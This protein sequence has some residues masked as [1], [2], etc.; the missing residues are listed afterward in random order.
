VSETGAVIDVIGADNGSREFLQEVIILVGALGRGEKGK[1]VGPMI[2]LDSLELSRCI[3]QGG[4]PGSLLEHSITTHQ[5][6]CQAARVLD[7]LMDIPAFDTQF[8]LIDRARL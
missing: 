3:I 6:L 7:E 1:A 8:S 4:L 5:G 2:F